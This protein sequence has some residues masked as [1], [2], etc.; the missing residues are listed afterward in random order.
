VALI[1]PGHDLILRVEHGLGGSRDLGARGSGAWSPATVSVAA[2][3]QSWAISG[4]RGSKQPGLGSGRFSS[5]WVNHLGVLLGSAGLAATRATAWAA[6]VSGAR[7][8]ARVPVPRVAY[9]PRRLALKVREEDV[10]LTKARDR[11]ERGGVVTSTADRRRRRSGFVGRAAAEGLRAL[12]HLG[13][14]RGDPAKVPRGLGESGDH[15]RRGI[16]RAERL[17]GGGFGFN[18]GTGRTRGSKQRPRTASWR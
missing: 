7:R 16:A 13:S 11:L 18:S 5:T 12:G 8:R 9:D 2:L 10:V 1:Y 3:R 14:M 15:R 17:T 4:S 6:W